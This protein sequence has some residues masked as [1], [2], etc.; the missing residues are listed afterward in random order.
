MT[1]LMCSINGKPAR[2]GTRQTDIGTLNLGLDY[3][4]QAPLLPPG[5]F[6]RFLNPAVRVVPDRHW[7]PEPGVGLRPQ[8]PLLPPGAYKRFL[9]PVV[10]DTPDRHWDPEPGVGLHPPGPFAATGHF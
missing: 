6:K 10:R 1:W 3:V 7:D 2:W 8:A 5:A 9:I 4:P